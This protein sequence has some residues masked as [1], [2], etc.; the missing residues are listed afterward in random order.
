MRPFYNLKLTTRII[1][2]IMLGLLATAA[3]LS[4][5]AEDVLE[6]AMLAQAKHQALIYL[7]GLERDIQDLNIAAEP[8]KFEEVLKKAMHRDQNQLGFSILRMYAYDRNGNIIAHT[9]GI[10]DVNKEMDSS[11]TN[12]FGNGEPILGDEIELYHNP[13]TGLIEHKVDIVV[14]IQQDDKIIA[15]LEVELG[16]EDTMQLIQQL[17]N[18][19]EYQLI[20][21]VIVSLGVVLLFVTLVIRRGLISPLHKLGDLTTNIANGD[22]SSRVSGLRDDEFGRLGESVN[23]M[24]DSIEQLFDE[25]EKAYLQAIQSLAKALEAKDSYTAKHSSRVAKYSVMLGRRLGLSEEELRLL[26]QGALMHDLGKIGIS[27]SILNKPA[28]LDDHEFEIMRE[29]PSFTAAIMKPLKRFEGFTQI[30][31]WHHER[32]DGNGYPDG[33]AGEDI[34]L[35]ARIVA[36]ADSWDAMTGDRVY[37]KGMDNDTAIAIMERER[38]SGQ[39]DPHLLGIFIEM[40]HGEQQARHDIEEDMHTGIGHAPS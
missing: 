36:I 14:P 19:Y 28:P 8:K 12:L 25:Q 31:A 21:I 7:M 34:P 16:V 33:L 10:T 40:I 2:L 29:H 26:K 4:W 11:Y 27:D 24:A 3:V 30:A 23:R 15:G 20:G 18:N 6:E 32:W 38:D 17:D 9:D 39:W 37:R 22:F 5:H 35:L 13:Q 1:G